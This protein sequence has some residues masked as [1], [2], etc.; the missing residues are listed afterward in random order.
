MKV[1]TGVLDVSKF[2]H[3]SFNHYNINLNVVY[4]FVHLYSF[5]CHLQVVS[6]GTIACI[7]IKVFVLKILCERKPST[8][9]T[10]T[11]C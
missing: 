11:T 7:T 8:T 2:M 5:I 1:S 4:N 10:T 6:H 9:T 3:S